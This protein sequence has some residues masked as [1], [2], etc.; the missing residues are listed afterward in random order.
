MTPRL[1]VALDHLSG[2]FDAVQHG[3]GNVHYDNLRVQAF[4]EAHGFA[5]VSGL[6]HNLHASVPLQQEA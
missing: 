4:R 1:G 5:P 3:H 2:G 6:P